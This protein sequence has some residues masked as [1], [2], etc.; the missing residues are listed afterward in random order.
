MRN[1]GALETRLEELLVCFRRWLPCVTALIA[2]AGCGPV[3]ATHCTFVRTGPQHHD[4]VMVASLHN[5]SAK[6][7]HQVGVAQGP[8]EFEFH[9]RLGPFGSADRVVGTPIIS[10]YDALIRATIGNM[11]APTVGPA[12]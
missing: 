11:R 5:Y 7:L 10:Y 6:P 8:V 12:L 3:R 1:L 2:L 4:L 9:V